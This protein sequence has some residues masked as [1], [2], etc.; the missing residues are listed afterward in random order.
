MKKTF[1]IVFSGL[2]FILVSFSA[3][4]K[5]EGSPGGFNLFTVNDDMAFGEEFSKEIESNPQDYPLLDE[6]TFTDAYDHVY[7]IR[8]SILNTGLV[9]YDNQFVW[10][11]KIVQNDTVNNAFAVPGGYLYFYTGII[12]FLDNEAEFAGVM[13]HEMAHAAR[14]HSTNQLT[15]AYTIQ[16]LLGIILGN[17]PNQLA[18][19][20][21]GLASGLASLAFSRD[22]ENDADEWSVKY[23]N[24]TSYNPRGI[25]AFFEKMEGAPAPPTFMSTHP[26]PDNRME[27]I[28][29]IWQS[30]GAKEGNDYAASYEAFKN[31]LP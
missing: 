7:R 24:E 25:R 29:E 10:Q 12:K 2:L 11:V 1:L 9:N 30:L 19:I 23:L 3:C 18:E 28:D 26:S 27:N 5:D 21:A 16:I 13:G 14:R 17:N 4:N 22:H 31:S 20:A 8:D 6:G 15:K